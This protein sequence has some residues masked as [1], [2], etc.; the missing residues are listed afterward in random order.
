M[1]EYEQIDGSKAQRWQIVVQAIKYGATVDV[2]TS[3]VQ[4][5]LYETLGPLDRQTSTESVLA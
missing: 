1:A 4:E 2:V 5:C 3:K